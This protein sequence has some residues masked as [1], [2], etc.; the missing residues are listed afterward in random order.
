V[1][2]GG[3]QYRHADGRG[4]RR[5]SV[6]TVP[7]GTFPRAIWKSLGGFDES[8]AA[9]QDFDFNYRARQAGFAVILDRDIRATYFA[10]PTLRA[11]ARQYVRYGYWKVQMLRKDPRATHPRQLPPALVLPWVVATTGWALLWPGPV[12]WT[13]AALYPVVIAGAAV[14]LAS[15]GV[16]VFAAAAAVATVHMS[17]SAGFWKAA[18]R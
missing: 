6:E 1:G 10:R 17:W 7:F 3:A 15:G 13:A 2:S 4:P 9:N 14:H 8:L 18:I 11:L 16:N 5:V 12:S